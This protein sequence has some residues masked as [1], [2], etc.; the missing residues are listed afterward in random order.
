MVALLGLGAALDL[1]HDHNERDRLR[2]LRG[3]LLREVTVVAR[4]HPLAGRALAV[5]GHRVVGGVECLLVRFAAWTGRPD[6]RAEARPARAGTGRGGRCRRSRGQLRA[7][8]EG[9]LGDESDT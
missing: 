9:R 4:E 8:L 3:S 7:L 1:A 5:T 2:E 6:G